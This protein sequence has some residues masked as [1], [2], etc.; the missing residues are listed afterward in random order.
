MLKQFDRDC[1]GK[2][3]YGEFTCFYAEAKARYEEL[4]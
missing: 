1:N 3:D 2:L 4:Y